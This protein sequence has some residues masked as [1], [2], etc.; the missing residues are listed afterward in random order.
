MVAAGKPHTLGSGISSTC[1]LEVE[2]RHVELRANRNHGKAGFGM[3]G[4]MKGDDLINT[5][6]SKASGRCRTGVI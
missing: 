2:A 6:L 3:K 4:E 5:I 1:D